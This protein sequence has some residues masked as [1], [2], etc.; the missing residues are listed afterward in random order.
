MEVGGKRQA[1]TALAPG[2]IGDPCTKSRL[3]PRAGQDWCVKSLPHWSLN[4]QPPSSLRVAIPTEL[5]RP[6]GEPNQI[7]NFTQG[8]NLFFFVRIKY[9]I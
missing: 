2:K 3:G 8:N 9:M 1:P 5:S 4:P 7:N 6:I